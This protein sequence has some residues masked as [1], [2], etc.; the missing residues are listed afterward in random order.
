LDERH[1][2]VNLHGQPKS[3]VNIRRDHGART[4][5]DPWELRFRFDFSRDQVAGQRIDLRDERAGFRRA[6]A[7]A[8]GLTYY[9]RG[10]PLG[11]SRDHGREPPNF[12][13]PFWRAT[14]VASDVD[15]R[16]PD[17]GDD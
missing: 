14:L 1:A 9:H 15:E 11:D 5:P 8:T 7:I 10:Q 3:M 6:T 17:R 16:Y 12:L 2:V 13:N 4:T